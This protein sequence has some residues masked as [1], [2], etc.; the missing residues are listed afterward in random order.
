[1]THV[2]NREGSLSFPIPH[3]SFPVRFTTLPSGAKAAAEVEQDT[4]EEIRGCVSAILLYEKGQRPEQP[5]FGI[6]SPLFEDNFIETKPI[7]DALAEWEPRAEIRMEEEI[8][9][10]DPLIRYVDV[11]VGAT[12]SGG[13][14][15]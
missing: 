13:I 7:I 6:I 4:Y 2:A 5:G 1:M 14:N 12:S 8:D 15:A 10:T 3:L 11:I 9:V